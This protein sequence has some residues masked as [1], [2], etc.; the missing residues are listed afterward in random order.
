MGGADLF[1]NLYLN[2]IHSISGA[3][4]CSSEKAKHGAVLQ[5]QRIRIDFLSNVGETAIYVENCAQSRQR[6]TAQVFDAQY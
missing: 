3:L 2:M 5:H 6:K 1:Y 4:Y